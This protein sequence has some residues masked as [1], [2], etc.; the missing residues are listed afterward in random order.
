VIS[1]EPAKTYFNQLRSDSAVNATIDEYV[2]S[3][4]APEL[5]DCVI[6]TCVLEHVPDPAAFIACAYRLLKPGGLLLIVVPNA[7]SLHRRHGKHIGVIADLQELQDHDHA[8]GHLRYYTQYTLKECFN[9]T[10]E[11]YGIML[12]PFPNFQMDI[13]SNDAIDALYIES[14][15]L[16]ACYAAEI[17]AVAIKD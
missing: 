14:Q 7:G 3:T 11:I 15:I 10:P 16:P 12:K 2:E 13:L 8:F 6:S 5:A 1:I 9:P 17:I 4:P